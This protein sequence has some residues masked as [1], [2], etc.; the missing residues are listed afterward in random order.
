MS[1]VG[2][3]L[4]RLKYWVKK[5]IAPNTASRAGAELGQ[6]AGRGRDDAEGDQD[7]DPERARPLPGEALEPLVL[8]RRD[9]ALGLERCPGPPSWEDPRVGRRVTAGHP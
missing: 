1:D 4:R 3:A 5:W 2:V 9:P 8:E 7:V 6:G